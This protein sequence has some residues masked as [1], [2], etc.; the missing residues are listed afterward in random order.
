MYQIN[1][2]RLKID[3]IEIVFDHPIRDFI[4]IDNMI[5]VYLNYIDRVIPMDNN[6]FGVSMMDRKVRW[7][8]ETRKY[9]QGGN[10]EMRCPFVGISFSDNKLWLYNWCSKKLNVDPETG[11]VL[12]EIETR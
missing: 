11:K 12:Q 6:V 3:E 7:Q 10:A 8:I 5:I 9:L 4:E 1:T 2:D